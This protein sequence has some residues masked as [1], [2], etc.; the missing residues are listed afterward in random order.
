[1]IKTQSI[2]TQKRIERLIE[3][4]PN[5]NLKELDYRVLNKQPKTD[6]EIIKAYGTILSYQWRDLQKSNLLMFDIT[7]H[8]KDN[9]FIGTRVDEYLMGLIL[10]YTFRRYSNE[11]EMRTLIDNIVDYLQKKGNTTYAEFIRTL[12]ASKFM[13]GKVVP[14]DVLEQKATLEIAE[15]EEILTQIERMHK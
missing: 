2:D 14:Y 1:M 12:K 7:S 13:R 5:V 4:Y 15:F 9:G 6:E 11:Q 8:L 10:D 3:Q